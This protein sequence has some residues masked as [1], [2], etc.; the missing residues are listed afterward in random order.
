M[1]ILCGCLHTYFFF[2]G[3]YDE[4]EAIDFSVPLIYTGLVATV[5]MFVNP[6]PSILK[7]TPKYRVLILI[8]S[9]SYFRRAFYQVFLC[10][11]AL[12]VL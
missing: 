10:E 5:A 6:P 9:I 7:L 8:T 2:K 3:K 12:V 1:M 11:P 4:G